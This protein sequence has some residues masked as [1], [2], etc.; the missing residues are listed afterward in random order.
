[1]ACNGGSTQI[2]CINNPLYDYARVSTDIPVST[3]IN[4]K[5]YAEQLQSFTS[6]CY[7]FA[8]C[9]PPLQIYLLVFTPGLSGRADCDVERKRLK[10]KMRES[11]GEKPIL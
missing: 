1:M 4:A 5:Q 7:S 11:N 3:L 6:H 8:I 10:E 9:V 2:T